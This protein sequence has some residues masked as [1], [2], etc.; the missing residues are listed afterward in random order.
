MDGGDLPGQKNGDLCR[1][2]IPL[3]S[4]GIWED[5]K[6]EK[7]ILS[8]PLPRLQLQ[9]AAI[10]L[11]AQS[12]HLLL[13]RFHLPR[14]VPEILAGII[15][16]P[17]FLGQIPY[18]TDTFFP[19]EGEVFIRSLSKIGFVFFMFLIGVKMDPSIVSKTGKKAWT[20]GVFSVVL[21][22]LLGLGMSSVLDPMVIIYRRPALR[23]VIGVQTLTPF[24]VVACLLIDLKIMNSELGRLALASALIS[25]LLSTIVSTLLSIVRLGF[26]GWTSELLLKSLLF[27]VAFIVI[28]VFVMRPAL[29]WIIRQ[30]PEGK[31]VK[32]GYIVVIAATVMMLA[33]VSD[34]LGLQY[35]L[36]PFILGLSVPDGPPLGST[37]V[38]R[39][40]SLTTGLLAP[41]LS[42]QCGLKVNLW[43]VYD[44]S[45]M[46]L[47]WIVFIV[48]AVLKAIAT[49]IPAYLCNVPNKDAFALSVIMNAQGIV[50]M[51]SYLNN[52]VG[53]VLKKHSLCSTL[54]DLKCYQT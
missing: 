33:I 47:M 8:H 36:G 45:F 5:V 15:M 9:L 39:L 40:D 7:G 32:G 12:L 18:F 42:A 10:F 14:I 35:Q 26:A 13:R 28:I 6:E 46:F 31:P 41:L 19:E 51:S 2:H 37:L 11:V 30:T 43:A 50:E 24:A 48:S 3:H 1:V 49:L 23:S 53:Q 54:Q 17:T 38:E 25:D 21:P 52:F 27:T 4:K 20:I 34:N 29:L 22:V 44:K 16:G